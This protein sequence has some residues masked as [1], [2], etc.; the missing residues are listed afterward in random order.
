VK[1]P[2]HSG[3]LTWDGKKPIYKLLTLLV[4]LILTF[5][6]MGAAP[7]QG[8]SVDKVEVILMAGSLEEAQNIGRG[9]GGTV[10]HN[11][12]I[13]NGAVVRVPPRCRA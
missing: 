4:A 11:L 6:T 9:A 3:N 7:L 12:G 13:I 8:N 2:Y 1:Q 10:T 5:S